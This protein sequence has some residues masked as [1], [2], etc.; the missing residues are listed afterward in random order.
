MAQPWLD[1][2]KTTLGPDDNVENTYSCTLNNQIGYLCLGTSKLVFVNVKG[3]LRKKYE[4]L[5]DTPYDELDDV[6]LVDRFG[7]DLSHKDKIH[8]IETSDIPGKILAEEIQA[9]SKGP[10]AE[11]L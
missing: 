1:L 11:P 4:V 3:F 6:F 5:L 8:H 7:V 10:S 2:A 9:L